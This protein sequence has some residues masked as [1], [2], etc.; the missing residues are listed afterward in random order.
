MLPAYPCTC[1]RARTQPHARAPEEST[2]KRTRAECGTNSHSP[3][4][5]RAASDAF[6]LSRARGKCQG[7][8]RHVVSFFRVIARISVPQSRSCS[9]LQFGCCLPC[10]MMKNKRNR[11]SSRVFPLAPPPPPSPP[12]ESFSGLRDV[13]MVILLSVTP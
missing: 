11:P 5:I 3:P 13:A 6:T 9:L 8:P 12:R 7:D 4:F 2:R 1:T 10:E